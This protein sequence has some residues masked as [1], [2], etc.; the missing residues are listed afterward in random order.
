MSKIVFRNEEIRENG[1]LL[2]KIR[3]G[4]IRDKSGNLLGKTRDTEIRERS[5][6]LLG[7]TK[8]GYVFSRSGSRIGKVSDYMIEDMQHE[9]DVDIVACYHFLV[10]KIF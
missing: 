8:D 4:E 9:K 6:N 3:N 2:G 10:K 1:S 7:K 5:G